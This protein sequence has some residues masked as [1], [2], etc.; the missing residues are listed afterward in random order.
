MLRLQG[1]PLRKKLVTIQL[2]DADAYAWGGEALALD[3]VPAGELASVGWSP[4]AG[5]CVALAYLRGAAANRPHAG[6]AV[7]VDLWGDAV[8]ATAWDRW[9]PP[10]R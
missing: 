9:P 5:A 6:P 8:A 1:A 2:E 10:A 7:V 4:K 3:G